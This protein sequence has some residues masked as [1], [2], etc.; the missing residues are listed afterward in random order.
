VVAGAPG[1]LVGRQL[2]PADREDSRA[3]S[4]SAR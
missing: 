1:S 3:D 2:M 4:S